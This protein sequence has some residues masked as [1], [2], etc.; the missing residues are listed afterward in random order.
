M[1]FRNLNVEIVASRLKLGVK[2]SSLTVSDDLQTDC[3]AG[4]R[5]VD[6]ATQLRFASHSLTRELN[7]HIALLQ[8]CLG[9]RAVRINVRHES[10]ILAWQFQVP[11]FVSRY[12]L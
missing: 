8:A 9:R 2:G 10:A 7:D 6:Q 4:R 11:N 12:I 1:Y 5:L 3:T